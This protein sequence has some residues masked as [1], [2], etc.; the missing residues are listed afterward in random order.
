MSNIA[1]VRVDVKNKYNDPHK[2]FKDMFAEFKRKVSSAGILHDHKE[3]QFYE[4][5]SEKARKKKQE[6]IAKQRNEMLE[7]KIMAGERVKAS[8][9]LI[10]KIT[11]SHN[12]KNNKNYNKDR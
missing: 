4:S 8:A 10:K 6:A 2:N 3:H 11:A 9:K 7:E 12:K 1:R 5:K